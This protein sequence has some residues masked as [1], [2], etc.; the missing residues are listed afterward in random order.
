MYLC[1][2]KDNKLWPPQ[3]HPILMQE[4]HQFLFLFQKQKTIMNKVHNHKLPNKHEI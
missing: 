4:M 2:K 3:I 1:K